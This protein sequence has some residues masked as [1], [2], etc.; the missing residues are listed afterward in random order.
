VLLLLDFEN[1]FDRINL[2]YLF[3]ALM[4]L[5]FD[6]LWTKWVAALYEGTSSS[7]KINGCPKLHLGYNK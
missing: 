2:G 5:G 6:P 3:E 1:A 7:I 4:R